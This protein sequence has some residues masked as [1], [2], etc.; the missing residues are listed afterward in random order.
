ME[1]HAHVAKDRAHDIDVN[2]YQV[3]KLTQCRSR[4]NSRRLGL[5]RGEDSAKRGHVMPRSGAEGG[6]GESKEERGK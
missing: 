3:R 5:Y 1:K 6:R 4:G 2:R